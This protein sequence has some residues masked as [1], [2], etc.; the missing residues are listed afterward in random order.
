MST[1]SARR[2]KP[3]IRPPPKLGPDTSIKEIWNKLSHAIREIQNHNA[4]KLSFEEHYR[5]AYNMVLYKH[6]DQLYNGVKGIVAEHLDKLAEERIVPAFPR[7]SGTQASAPG[8]GAEAVERAVEGDRFLRAV[9][10]VWDDHTGSMRKLKDILRYMDKDYTRQQGLPAV[11]D[12][13]LQLFLSHIVRSPT[14]PIH[15][16]L[17]GTLLGQ[18]QLERD[19]LTIQRSSVADCVDFLLRLENS[20]RLGGRSVYSTDFEP[21][22]LRRSA[23]FYRQEA[24]AQLVKADSSAYLRNVERRLSEENDRTAHYLWS[25]TSGPLQLLVVDQLLTPHL[26]AIMRM[27]GTGLVA[28]LD[29]DRRDDLRRLYTLFLRVP[30]DVGKDALRLALRDSVEARGKAINDS[31]L[32]A[33]S[34]PQDEEEEK[35][36]P[37]GKGKAKGPSAGATALAQALRW[38]QDVLDLKDKFDRILDQAFGGDKQ[39]QASINEA[40]Q[41]FINA[42]QRSPEFLSLFIDEHLKKG[43]KVKSEEEIEL[44]LEKTLILFRFLSDK[45]KF[46][47]YYKVHLAR[48]LLYGR[49]ASDDA[50][51]GM[52]AKLKIEMGFQFVQKLEGMFNDMRLSADSAKSFQAYQGRHGAAPFDMSVKVLTASYWPQQIVTTNTCRF[53]EPLGAATQLYQRYYDSR[54]SG[55]RLTWQANLGTAD[56]RVRFKARPHDLNV[57]TQALVV[58]LLFEEVKEG[59]NLSYEEIKAATDLADSDLQRTLQSLACGKY[60]VLTKTPKGREVNLSDTFAFNDGFTS[61][62]ARIKIMQIA[63]KVETPKE[64]EETQEMVDEERKHQV[65]ACI[66]RI[67]KSRKTMGHNDL[68]SEVALQL[69]TRF[70]PSTGLIKKRIEGLIDREYLERTSDI[71]VYR[72]LA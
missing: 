15:T 30:N 1:G 29:G 14:H 17:M 65:E 40:F 70:Q 41:S 42:N 69:S 67:M 56:V 3:K 34:A 5:Y 6:G 9:K 23:E 45:D 28:M 18:V 24:I 37:K 27:P 19:G 58:L 39:V 57:S 52:V 44:A 55:R 62:L 8:G 31:A 7:A 36:D 38:V 35:V 49:S 20:E 2:P 60:R 16:H 26:H 33:A 51:R 50:E 46:E 21:E 53:G 43:A 66:V 13:G 4:S 72:Y 64:R 47:R 68:V 32:A 71:G 61:P 11:Y 12:A 10:G 48:R 54:H 59:E 25:N 22:F 63:S